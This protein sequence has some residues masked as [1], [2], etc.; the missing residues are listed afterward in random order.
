[1]KSVISVKAMIETYVIS[2][3]AKRLG[4]CSTT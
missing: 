1:M 4:R 3:L 2:K